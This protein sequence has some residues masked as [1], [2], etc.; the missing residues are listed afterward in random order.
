MP[1][2]HRQGLTWATHDIFFRNRSIF[3]DGVV[4]LSSG[5]IGIIE[6][7]VARYSGTEARVYLFGSRLDDAARG[8][9]VDLLI[10]TTKA[11]PR[12]KQAQL[13]AT[14][15]SGLDLPVDI[16]TTVAHSPGSAFETMVRQQAVLLRSSNE[17]PC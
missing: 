1:G 6:T 10:E 8:G 13:K 9:D 3:W 12:I 2:G 14:L 17:P 4:R 15:E 11:L 16:L 5:Q 7:I